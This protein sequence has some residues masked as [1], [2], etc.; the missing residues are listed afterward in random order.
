MFALMRSIEKHAHIPAT[1]DGDLP[2]SAFSDGKLP[3]MVIGQIYMAPGPDGREV[4]ARLSSAT[5]NT[6]TSEMILGFDNGW[7]CKAPMSEAE[8]EDYKQFPDTFFGIHHQQGG[9]TESPLELFDFMHDSYKNTAREKLL[10]WMANAS[11]IAELKNLTH[12]ELSEIY[13]ERCVYSILAAEQ[14]ARAG[15][16]E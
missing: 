3:R 8:L 12:T 4:P 14:K 2:S 7:I 1:F 9:K 11:D 6:S 13:C 16:A 5:V 15:K 10:G